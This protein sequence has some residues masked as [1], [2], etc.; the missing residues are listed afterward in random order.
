MHLV[1][2]SCVGRGDAPQLGGLN[3]DVE[4][5]KSEVTGVV[6]KKEALWLV[7]L[8]GDGFQRKSEEAALEGNMKCHCLAWQC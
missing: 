3:A 7:L 6:V 8:T 2:L 4:G 5:G 1:Y